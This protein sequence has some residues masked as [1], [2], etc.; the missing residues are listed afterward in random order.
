MAIITSAN[1]IFVGNLVETDINEADYLTENASAIL[2]TYSDLVMTSV[3]QSDG[4]HDGAIYD[5]EY[6]PGN[7]YI[8]YDA[9]AGAT[10][11]Y[12]DSSVLYTA[13]ITLG[14]GSTIVGDFVVIQAANGDTFIRE[15]LGGTQLDNLSIQSISLD[16]VSYA[17][18]AGF[19]TSENLSNTAVVCFAT[20]VEIATLTG[21]VPVEDLR[22]GDLVHTMDH[23]LQP[24]RWVHSRTLPYAGKHAPIIFNAGVL[25][26]SVPTRPIA[27]SP[28][29]RVLLR[30]RIAK[31]MFGKDEVFVSA[32]TLLTLPG[33][34]RGA[35]F[36]PV[37]YHHFACDAHEIIFANGTP[38]E[39]FY[40]GPQALKALP[41]SALDDLFNA[42]F[43]T[44]NKIL[45][46]PSPRGRQQRTL[47]A[48]HAK[49]NVPVQVA[50][51]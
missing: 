30:S 21:S 45:A 13:T 50:A 7:D 33:V 35:R 32:K 42:E 1:M 40:P 2:G 9:G 22:S 36:M 27:L 28:Q 3:T 31:R 14:D 26:P 19:N 51:P 43:D 12:V 41:Q 8:S 34:Y 23:G 20:G 4:D 5:D 49:N 37:T 29:H 47:L 11:Q 15:E 48:R 46:R 44:P 17:N 18:G 24:I 16:S 39:T 6:N 25:A 10:A 38:A